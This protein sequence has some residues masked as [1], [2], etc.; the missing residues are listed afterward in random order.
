MLTGV[1]VIEL[2]AS[3]L[4]VAR[5]VLSPSIR[6]T[7]A[8]V[9]VPIS[10]RTDWGITMLANLI[11]L[12]PGTTTLHVSDSRQVLYVHVLDTSDTESTVATIKN[13]FE[14]RIR[15]VEGWQ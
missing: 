2:F 15:E 13:T 1:F 5:A 12:T 11:S 8:I 6:T 10:L 7:P 14:R 9:A 3:A 4:A